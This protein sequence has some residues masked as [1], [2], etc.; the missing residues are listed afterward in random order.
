[1]SRKNKL[2]RRSEELRVNAGELGSQQV[3]DAPVAEAAPRMRDLDDLAAEL[4]RRIVQLRR[5]AIDV[6]G[7]PHK[8]TR[9]ALR[10]VM[11][12]HHLADRLALDL[13]G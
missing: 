9:S 8:T 3:V 13:W 7:E 2:A 6:A 4:L 10:Q 1:L 12:A 5:M 11:L